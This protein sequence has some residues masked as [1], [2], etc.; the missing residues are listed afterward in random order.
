[1]IGYGLYSIYHNQVSI[2]LLTV[3]DLGLSAVAFTAI[4]HTKLVGP[5]GID[6]LKQ[7]LDGFS[8]KG[9]PAILTGYAT[10]TVA[11]VAVGVFVGG[12]VGIVANL[13]WAWREYRR[14]QNGDL[15]VQSE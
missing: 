5:K 4:M 6:H 10:A 13:P 3:V 8:T 1:M 14:W 11:G 7:I 2:G 12:G 15:R 9:S